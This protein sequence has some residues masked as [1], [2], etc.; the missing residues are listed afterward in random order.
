MRA[1][2][3]LVIKL[4]GLLMVREQRPGAMKIAQTKTAADLPRESYSIYRVQLRNPVTISELEQICTVPINALSLDGAGFS[5]EHLATVGKA[6]CV[7][8]LTLGLFPFSDAGMQHLTQCRRLKELSLHNS[9][10]AHLN[11]QFLRK[12]ESLE[13]FSTTSPTASD[14]FLSGLAGHP[15]LKYVS[16]WSATVTGTVF[17]KFTGMPQFVELELDRCALTSAGL[18][19]IVTSLPQLQHLAI[20]QSPL[21]DESFELLGRLTNLGHLELSSSK[22]S[23]AAIRKIA[24]PKVNMLQLQNTAVTG[25]GFRD[26]SNGFPALQTCYLS[27]SRFTNDGLQYLAAAAP[28]ISYLNLDSTA[29]TDDGLQH[30]VNFKNL[31]SLSL[32]KTK[33]TD[34]GIEHLLGLENLR[35]VYLPAASCTPA[36]AEKLRKSLKNATVTLR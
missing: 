29:V 3:E 28:R 7:S 13:R 17:A 22:I 8:Q 21:T 33:V 2:A 27:N 1:V 19:A 25:E 31:N 12:I 36:A 4:G 20:E 16:L 10:L 26:H 32:M 35:S 14:D 18:Q 23:D 15:R 11:G 30:L 34:R 6:D 24:L 5:D 9:S